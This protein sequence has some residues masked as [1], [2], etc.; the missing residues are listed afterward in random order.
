[1][2]RAGALPGLLLML[3][4][5]RGEEVAPPPPP[6]PLQ[7][8]KV[9]LGKLLFSDSTLSKPAGQSCAS[10]HAPEAGFADPR[11]DLPVSPGALPWRAGNR[12]TPTLAYARYSPGMYYD[13]TIP[14]WFGGFFM[15]GRAASLLDQAK[16]P[17]LN[18]LEMNN[19][20]KAS[21]VASVKASG[22]ANLFERAFGEGI[23]ERTDEA[24]DKIAEALVAYQSSSEV[25]RFSSKFDFVRQGQARFT[26]AEQRGLDLFKDKEKS[27]CSICH[28]IEPLEDGTPPLFSDY[29]YDSVGT[30][31]N[32]A[33]PFYGMPAEFNPQGLDWVDLGVGRTLGDPTMNGKFKTPTLRNIA[34]TAPYM[35]N[36]VFKTLREVLDFYNTRDVKPTWAPPEVPETVN[37][38][39]MGDLKLT[40]AELAD[41]EAFLLTLTDGYVPQPSEAGLSPRE[42]SARG[43]PACPDVLYEHQGA[44]YA[45]AFSAR[46]P[47]SSLGQ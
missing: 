19:P 16:Q 1:M 46:P 2:M 26:E 5:C 10:C 42:G 29:G 3:S 27:K 13:A 9:V 45:P 37:K 28:D 44:C 4:G 14:L 38:T 40:D 31:R 30:P 34:L 17:F 6:D 32:P 43:A 22:Y 41:L 7:V 23:F 8:D 12:N 24:Y 18:P 35:H 20:D 11:S 36:G 39:E 21:V 15:D 33:N 47:P 25:Q